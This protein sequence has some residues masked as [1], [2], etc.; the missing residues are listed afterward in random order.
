MKIDHRV[1]DSTDTNAIATVDVAMY[2]LKKALFKTGPEGIS[3][4]AERLDRVV[5]CMDN[6]PHDRL[7]GSAPNDDKGNDEL[8]FSLLKDAA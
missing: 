6:T 2:A 5:A 4:W 8:R 1:K 3:N 7:R